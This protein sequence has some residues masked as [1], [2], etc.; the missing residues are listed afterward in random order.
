MEIITNSKSILNQLIDL[1][2]T[3]SKDEYSSQLKVLNK[4]TIGQHVRHIIEFYIEFEKGYDLGTIAY[5]NRTRNL[6]FEVNQELVITE[7]QNIIKRL[8]NYNLE[9]DLLLKSNYGLAH[10]DAV[11]SKTSS[12]REIVYILDHAVHHLA[13][14]KIAIQVDYSHIQ[15]NTNLGIAPSTLRNNKQL[16]AQ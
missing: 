2:K 4:S 16:C 7:L 12:R 1:I 15:L 3:M 9:K 13:I 5:D 14:I 11:K 6:E 8:T 10:S